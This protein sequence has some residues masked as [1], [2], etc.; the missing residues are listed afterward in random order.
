MDRCH[1]KTG[2]R[3]EKGLLSY[4]IVMYMPQLTGFEPYPS[5]HVGEISYIWSFWGPFLLFP[6]QKWSY[7]KWLLRKLCFMCRAGVELKRGKGLQRFHIL[8]FHEIL[9]HCDVISGGQ[10]KKLL[11]FDLTLRFELMLDIY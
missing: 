11:F 8:G 1:G 5:V 6:I 4:L 9:G 2:E 3:I 10:R 7:S